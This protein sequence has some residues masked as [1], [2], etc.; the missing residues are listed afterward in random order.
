[1]SL[2][3]GDLLS[4]LAQECNELLEYL[5][6]NPPSGAKTG[7]DVVDIAFEDEVLEP[8]LEEARP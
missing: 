6:S 1:V 7:T 3:R 5:N 4:G 8:T 2:R